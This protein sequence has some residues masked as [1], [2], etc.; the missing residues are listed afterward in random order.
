[1]KKRI[2]HITQSTGGVEEYLKMFFSH[3]D[4]EH[5]EVELI[6]PNY[7]SM[8]TKM[9]NIGVKVHIVNMKRELC[10]FSDLKAYIQI[11]NYIKHFKPDIVHVHS[12]KAGVL[13]RF[14]AYRN[15]VPCIY[16]SHGWSFSM[17]ISEKKKRIYAFIERICARYTVKIIN[18]SDD[19][20][21]LAIKYKIAKEDKMITIY[22]GIDLNKY[23]KKYN[24]S[25]IL[26]KLNIPES[27]FVIGM[28]A[29]IT[30]QKSP[31]VFISIAEKISN[32]VKNAYFI[33]VGDGNL[34]EE[35]QDI[36]EEKQLK[37]KV[38]ITGWT[39]EVAKYISIFNIGILTSKWE[40]FGL[41]LAEYMAS[42][43]PTVASNVGGIPNVISNNRNGILI[44]PND[45]DGFVNAIISIKENEKMTNMFIEN[46][47]IDVR[48]KFDINRVVEEHEKLYMEVLK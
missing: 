5:F 35:I 39:N 38:I 10:F 1:M 16:N 9:E 45:I 31:Q 32:I 44:E 37:E 22:N 48:K 43:K 20:K 26:S 28:V 18:I 33:L 11:N 41:V 36:I 19:E 29:R 8:I 24:R 34:K 27:A 46:S 23:S 3:I 42:G 21:K 13:G 17:D 25:D 7:P 2:L 47:Y 12:S 40:G 6:C 4:K 14:A 15:K 30:E